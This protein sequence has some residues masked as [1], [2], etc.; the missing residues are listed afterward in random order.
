MTRP[1]HTPK[2]CRKTRRQLLDQ[3]EAVETADWRADQRRREYR[4][5]QELKERKALAERYRQRRK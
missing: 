1:K 2:R 5:S 4:A 3:A